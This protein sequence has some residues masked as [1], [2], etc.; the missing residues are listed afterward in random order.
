MF[1]VCFLIHS[2]VSVNLSLARSGYDADIS[3]LVDFTG[4]VVR[5]ML[6]GSVAWIMWAIA[7]RSSLELKIDAWLE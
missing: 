1:Q 3:K 4:D 2:L 7:Q 6:T 5:E